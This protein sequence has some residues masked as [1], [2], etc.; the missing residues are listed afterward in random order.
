MGRTSL[1]YSDKQ[2][3]S[4]FH[5]CAGSQFNYKSLQFSPVLS[6]PSI[7]VKYIQKPASLHGSHHHTPGSILTTSMFSLPTLQSGFHSLHSEMVEFQ[8]Q[9]GPQRPYHLAKFLAEIPSISFL[10]SNRCLK[11]SIACQGACHLG[12]PKEAHSIFEYT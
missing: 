3:I 12:S 7:L 1:L 4:S 6:L 2:Q 11:A 10:L 5:F 9:E 8:S